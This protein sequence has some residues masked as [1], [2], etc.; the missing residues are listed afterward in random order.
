MQVQSSSTRRLRLEAP[1]VEVIVT[2]SKFA[3]IDVTT[4]F[5]MEEKQRWNVVLILKEFA[6]RTR[7][8]PQIGVRGGFGSHINVDHAVRAAKKIIRLLRQDQI[9]AAHDEIR[10]PKYFLR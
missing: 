6:L 2:K 5:E 7:A 3:R 9:S 8:R 4:S 1:G 10:V